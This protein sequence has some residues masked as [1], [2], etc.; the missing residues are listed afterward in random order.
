MQKHVFRPPKIKQKL[1]LFVM[2]NSLQ[3]FHMPK[4]SMGL[5][6]KREIYEALKLAKEKNKKNGT[7]EGSKV[8]KK[9][10]R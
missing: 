10:E 5:C 7:H 4:R 6:E 8:L 3:S 1:H 9:R 2:N